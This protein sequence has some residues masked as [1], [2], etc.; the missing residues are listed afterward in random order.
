MVS[1]GVMRVDR[2]SGAR[3]AIIAMMAAAQPCG[4]LGPSAGHSRKR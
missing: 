1:I 2:W 4:R 3:A